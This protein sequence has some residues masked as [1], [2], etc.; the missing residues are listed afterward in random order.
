MQLIFV[1]QTGAADWAILQLMTSI[2]QKTRD[3]G[4]YYYV[5]QCSIIEQRSEQ[6]ESERKCQKG[7]QN[8]VNDGLCQIKWLYIL[9]TA[10][11]KWASIEHQQL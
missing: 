2:D 8:N 7:S 3:L 11:A 6:E 10:M 1:L 9:G 5:Y 4:D